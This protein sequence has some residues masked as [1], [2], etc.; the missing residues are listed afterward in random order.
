[1]ALNLKKCAMAGEWYRVRRTWMALYLP[2]L[3]YGSRPA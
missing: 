2:V 1:M 3:I